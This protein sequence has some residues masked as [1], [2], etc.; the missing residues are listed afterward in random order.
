LYLFLAIKSIYNPHNLFILPKGLLI[1]I[2]IF[3]TWFNYLLFILNRYEKANRVAA[4]SFSSTDIALKPIEHVEL[5]SISQRWWK[6]NSQVPLPIALYSFLLHT[7][8]ARD[9]D[10][11]VKEGPFFIYDAR[12]TFCMGFVAALDIGLPYY[13]IPN[14]LPTDLPLDF[15]NYVT[16]QLNTHVLNNILPGILEPFERVGKEFLCP[17]YDIHCWQSKYCFHQSV[18]LCSLAPMFGSHKM[19]AYM[20]IHKFWDSLMAL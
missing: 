8:V 7:F 19:S 15:E 2:N 5:T 17:N 14:P 1:N 13:I 9:V 20:E 18:P 3:E 16:S 11:S 6:N 4:G 10:I 12:P